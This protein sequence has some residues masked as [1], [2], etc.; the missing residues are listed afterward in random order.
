MNKNDITI[1]INFSDS[2]LNKVANM[3]LL[4][5]KPMPMG[6][7]IPQVETSQKKDA[8]PIGFKK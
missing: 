7:A 5:N 8:R 6:I 2:L 4:T 3:L 1:K